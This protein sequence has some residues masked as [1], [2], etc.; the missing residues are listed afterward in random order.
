[1]TPL[2]SIISRLRSVEKANI[3]GDRMESLAAEFRK[4][5]CRVDVKPGIIPGDVSNIRVIATKYPFDWCIKH[6]GWQTTEV[7]SGQHRIYARN[8]GSFQLE[9]VWRGA[10]YLKPIGSDW[11]AA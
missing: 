2:R 8:D 3:R 9:L 10:N 7:M 6:L 5:K 11:D 4:L 1:M